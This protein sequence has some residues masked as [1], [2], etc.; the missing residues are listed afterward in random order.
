MKGLLLDVDY[1]EEETRP[2]VRLFI[3]SGPETIVA[4]DPNF[5]EYLYATSDEPARTAKLIHKIELAEDGKLIKP[6]NVEVVKRTL[7]GKEIDAIKVSFHHPREAS[8]LR[9]AVRELPGVNDIYEFDLPPV[10]RYLVDRGLTPMAGVEFS[11]KVEAKDGVKTVVVDEPPKP[12]TVDEPKLNI[13][14]FDIEVYN[15][16]GSVRSDKDPITMMSMA[17]NRG[18]RKVI[19]WKNLDNNPDY[20][21][22]VGS[23]RDMIKRFVELVKERDVDILL[24]YNTDLF[25]I[26]YIRDR[27]RQL[28]VKLDLGRD[29]S[30]FVVRKRRF[31]TAS[32]IRGRV[33]VD[34]FAMVDFLATIGSIKLIHYSLAD[35]YRHMAGKEKPDF[36]FAEMINAWEKGGEE[37]RRFLEYSMSDADA[38]LELGLEFL[39][40]FLSLTHVVG[41]TLFDVQ[42][43]TSGQLVEWLL[44]AE[45]HKLGELVP[46]RPVGEEYEGRTEETFV[47]AY[48]M[49]P[50]KGLHENLAVF[51]F[52]SL[53]P[54]IIVSHNIDP[55]TINCK[56]CKPGERD[57]VPGMEYFFCKRRRGFIPVTLQRIIEERTKL[58][59][60]LKELKRGTK[61]YR[62]LDS[63]QWAMKI[64]ANSFYGMLGYPRARW[65]SKQC[66]ESVTSFGRH[67][68]HRTIEMAKDFGLE[69]I[70]G[71]TDS[72]HCKLGGKTR[73]DAMLFLKRVNESLPGIMELELEGFYPRGIFITKKRYA[74]TDEEGRMIVKGLEFVRRDWA[75]IAKRTQ[76]E[77]L[78]TILRD[79]S[80]KKAAE[81][82]RKTTR[83]VFEGRVDLKDLVIYTQLK[84]PI[85]SYRAIGPHVVA[86]KRLGKLGHKI[87][88]GMMIAYIE[89]KGPGSISERAFPVEDFKGREYDPEY[90]VGHQILP[91]VMRIMEVLGYNEGDLKF[92]KEKQVGL[93]QFMR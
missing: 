68:I 4:V 51:D 18:L 66:A 21:E 8:K 23:E 67:Y 25:D 54:S 71:D 82:I 29:G 56:D 60:K 57:Q 9:H 17:D 44:V 19:T 83:N 92:E 52:R 73:E 36:E 43:M 77:V 39:P 13:M 2:R 48:V 37:G 49:E 35:V 93:D 30:E 84:M 14:S 53:Y 5:E 59:T 76:E 70:Y 46:A 75:A 72:L 74:M 91:A 65:Y 1:A 80:P 26:P 88:P 79:G 86:A 40:L 32:K 87:E 28:K 47:G 15:P 45:A 12:T 62:A 58:K 85:E 89:A 6:K 38:T 11:G 10:R 41:Q 90:Y 24:G 55:S 42:R 64:V 69:V 3:K 78:R 22:V 81:I 7:L 50:A 63:Q 61:E 33:H 34:V 16:T 20:V 31:A 27:A